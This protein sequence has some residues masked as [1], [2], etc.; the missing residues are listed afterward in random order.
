MSLNIHF[1]YEILTTYHWSTTQLTW[2]LAYGYVYYNNHKLNNI[3]SLKYIIH[4]I[5]I[6]IPIIKGNNFV[7]QN[8]INWSYRILGKL[9]LTQ[10]NENIKIIVLIERLKA[11]IKLNNI[12][13]LDIIF[14]V[15][16]II[17]K[18]LKIYKYSFKSH[19]P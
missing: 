12:W 15:S 13:L 7:Q 8:D 19:M 6:I 18:L 9:A 14:I 3:D 2:L 10:I 17:F 11:Y 1:E 4:G 5:I 16:T